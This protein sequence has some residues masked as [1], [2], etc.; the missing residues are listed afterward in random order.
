ME[1]S[2]PG[3]HPVHKR[4]RGSAK[5]FPTSRSQGK[6][7]T[8]PSISRAN[9]AEPPF[10]RR[11]HWILFRAISAGR[12]RGSPTSLS[13]SLLIHQ[14]M[15]ILFSVSDFLSNNPFAWLDS[16]HLLTASSSSS[17]TLRLTKAYLE[18]A[19]CMLLL[20]LGR[21]NEVKKQ[22]YVFFFF[23]KEVSVVYWSLK[24]SATYRISGYR[25]D[26]STLPGYNTPLTEAFWWDAGLPTMFWCAAT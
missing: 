16:K 21:I 5:D 14:G 24:A 23:K 25:R 6:T 3:H 19:T 18:H 4:W 11:I 12:T 9:N 13:R 10:L 2:L 22:L 1:T 26:A 15:L 7:G 20:G 8:Q 17:F